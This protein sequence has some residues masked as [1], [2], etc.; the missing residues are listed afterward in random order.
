[1]TTNVTTYQATD[2]PTITVS[3]TEFTLN[4]NDTTIDAT[5]LAGIQITC[6]GADGTF[7]DPVTNPYDT[8]DVVITPGYEAIGGQPNEVLIRLAQ[9]LPDGLYRIT[10][11]GQGWDGV[12]TYYG[13]DGKPLPP[14][15]NTAGMPVGFGQISPAGQTPY[16]DGVNFSW[17]F[18]LTMAPQVTAV[19]PQPITRNA[20]GALSQARNQI[21]VYFS[22]DMDPASAQTLSFYSLIATGDTANTADDVVISADQRRLRSRR[23]DGHA[24]VQ[25]RPGHAGGQSGQQQLPPADRGPVPGDRDGTAEGRAATSSPPTAATTRSTTVWW[26]SAPRSRPRPIWAISPRTRP[27]P[28]TR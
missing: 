15:T 20:D 23:Q 4:F 22:E 13:P 9:P 2:Y 21:Q 1:M 26:T 27:S 24:H 14:L 3:P 11:V 6:A 12:H 5:T 7:Y 17:N 28:P 10:I 25:R 16:W 19:V 8:D 18:N